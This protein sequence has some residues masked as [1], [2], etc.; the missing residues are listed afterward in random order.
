MSSKHGSIFI[1]VILF[2]HKYLK[3]YN[4]FCY[5]Y[6]IEGA[7]RI[8][9]CW[10]FVLKIHQSAITFYYVVTRKFQRRVTYI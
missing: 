5:F 9:L 2:F 4:F 1:L 6:F 10:I 7:C 8:N 3:I